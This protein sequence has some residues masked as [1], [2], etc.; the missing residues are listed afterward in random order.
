MDDAQN[1]HLSNFDAIHDHVV[2]DREAAGTR[3]KVFIAAT[4]Q[5]REARQHEETIGAT[6]CAISAQAL[7]R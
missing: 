5:I 3:T 2:S 6:R 1:K 4:A 7:A